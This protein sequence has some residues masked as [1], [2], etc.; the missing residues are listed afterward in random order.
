MGPKGWI[1]FLVFACLSAMAS[2]ASFQS[3]NPKSS[4]ELALSQ[5]TSASNWSYYNV[6]AVGTAILVVSAGLAA[7]MSLFLPVMTFKLCLM[8][9]GCQDT[10]DRYV[11]RLIVDSYPRRQKR[12]MEYIEPIL[13]TLASAYEKYADDDVKKKSNKLRF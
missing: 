8:L 5:T 1:V 11:D 9:G 3:E 6:A 7:L 2:S 4:S 10:L 13:N 12:S